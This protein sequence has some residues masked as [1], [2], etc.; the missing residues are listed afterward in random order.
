MESKHSL[1]VCHSLQCFLIFRQFCLFCLR[2]LVQNE[3]KTRTLV[4]AEVACTREQAHPYKAWLSLIPHVCQNNGTIIAPH[5]FRRCICWGAVRCPC[6]HGTVYLTSEAGNWV[7][8]QP[9]SATSDAP[10][11]LW[12]PDLPVLVRHEFLHFAE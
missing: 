2:D 6:R 1:F 7:C 9:S 3:T 12:Y 11:S 4:F 10:A 5:L 8:G